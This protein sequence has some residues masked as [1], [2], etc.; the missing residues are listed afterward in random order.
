MASE[1]QAD[2]KRPRRSVNGTKVRDLEAKL[3]QREKMLEDKIRQKDKVLSDTQGAEESASAEPDEDIPI[4]ELVV[5]HA[6]L[7]KRLG[8]EA[9]ATAQ[10]K[11]RLDKARAQ[12]RESRPLLGQLRTAEKAPP[13]APESRR[14]CDRQARRCAEDLGRGIK[15]TERG[16]GT[17]F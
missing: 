5:H 1:G 8:P 4:E 7:E 14:C 2:N 10:L 6:T 16:N 9:A 15:G 13:A 3:R 17:P 11:A 12:K